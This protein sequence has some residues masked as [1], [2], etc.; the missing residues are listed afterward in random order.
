MVGAEA[1]PT[2]LSFHLNAAGAASMQVGLYQTNGLLC[3]PA[4]VSIL[5]PAVDYQFPGTKYRWDSLIKLVQQSGAF[6]D[7]NR[8]IPRSAAR[9]VG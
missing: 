8:L 6:R 9:P 5:M 4:N 7:Q 3:W 1:L 2:D